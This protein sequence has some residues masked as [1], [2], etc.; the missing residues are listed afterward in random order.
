[1]RPSP[2]RPGSWR[3]APPPRSWWLGCCG[4]SMG[5]IC[6]RRRTPSTP[7]CHARRL[8]LPTSRPCSSPPPARGLL[9]PNA[10]PPW[11]TRPGSVGHRWATRTIGRCGRVPQRAL[12]RRP[13]I[14]ISCPVLA[15]PA[16]PGRWGQAVGAGV[17]PGRQP[18]HPTKPAHRLTG[19]LPADLAARLLRLLD[20]GSELVGTQAARIRTA[21]D[22][23]GPATP[24]PGRGCAGLAGGRRT[25][26]GCREQL[27]GAGG[28][29]ERSRPARPA[30][31]AATTRQQRL[32][33][34]NQ[35]AHRPGRGQRT[36]RSSATSC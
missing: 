23:N 32:G 14:P 20:G 25:G 2:R 3:P 29:V 22:P 17:G 21:I 1:M 31:L 30:T 28:P 5:R 35:G 12:S 4:R 36:P 34:I 19:F 8:R 16:R 33:G 6:W 27:P 26:P 24:G 18:A 13:W 7:A 9:A 11:S 15:L 10:G